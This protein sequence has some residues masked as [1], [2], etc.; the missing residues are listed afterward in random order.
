MHF[1][2]QEKDTEEDDYIVRARGAWFGNR[3]ISAEVDLE[4]GV[5]EIVPKIVAKRDA[6]TP[7]VHEV[8]TKVAER[9]PQKLRQIGL[10]Y[11][12]ANAKGIME[13]T[14][15]EK[16]RKEAK[17]KEAAKMKKKEKEAADKDKAN[18]EAWGKE[19]KAEYEAWKKE[20]QQLEEQTKAEKAKSEAADIKPAVL[21]TKDASTSVAED[22]VSRPAGAA[23]SSSVTEAAIDATLGAT[24]PKPATAAPE[25]ELV[26]KTAELKVDDAAAPSDDD[27]AEHTP[28]EGPEN[29]SRASSRTVSRG[30]RLPPHM[31][32]NAPRSYYGDEPSQEAGPHARLPVD[33]KPKVWNAVCVL[34]LRVYSQD[35]EVS[36]KLLKPKNV[37]EGAILDVG[38]ETA[39]GATM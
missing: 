16:K 1:I 10:N 32:R 13:L 11:D 36:I 22:K 15:E 26:S 14:E 5:Y 4:P 28:D 3:S 19:E 33:G 30:R 29:H 20:K 34:G 7:D 8:V 9:N 2:L 18:F 12:I 23:A 37:E 21:E 24:E 39:A 6:D 25:A 31:Y 38:G 17:K 35:P 27:E